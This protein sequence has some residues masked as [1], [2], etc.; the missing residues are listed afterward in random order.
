MRQ[1]LSKRSVED[2]GCR[3]EK[4]RRQGV[5]AVE[6]ALCMPVI[7]VIML[8]I[9][10]VGRITQVSNVLWDGAREAARDASVGQ[11]NLQTVATNELTF[12]QN[13]LPSAFNPSHSTTLMAPVVT[14]PANTT[15]YTCWDNT[16]NQEMFTITFSDI[17]QPTVTDPTKMSKL[18]HY[19]IGLQVPYASIGWSSLS[20]ITSVNRIYITVDWACMQDA[21]F[22][23]SPILPAQ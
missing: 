18:D 5:A 17:T 22:Q 3:R 12:L 10:E 14:L 4:F 19:Q 11:D 2:C 6:F 7:L 9:W 21:P 23:V 13:A 15:G 16:A 8:G 1:H 20:Q